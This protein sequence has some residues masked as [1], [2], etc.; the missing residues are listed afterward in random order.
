[1]TLRHERHLGLGFHLDYSCPHAFVT[2][3]WLRYDRNGHIEKSVMESWELLC[4]FNTCYAIQA[5][6]DDTLIL[7]G[8]NK[9]FL[10]LYSFVLF[11]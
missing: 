1:V 10:Y 4:C 6:W 8:R 3:V 9:V 7:S 11:H 2:R 5:T